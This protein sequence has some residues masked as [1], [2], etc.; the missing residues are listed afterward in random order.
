MGR[1]HRRAVEG[2]ETRTRRICGPDVD[3]GSDQVE[4]TFVLGEVGEFRGCPRRE[5][6]TR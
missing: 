4:D 2:D 1:G 3:T 6:G 5:T